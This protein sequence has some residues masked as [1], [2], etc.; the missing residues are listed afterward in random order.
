[1]T[2]NVINCLVPGA[3][4]HLGIIEAMTF[5]ICSFEINAVLCSKVCSKCGRK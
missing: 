1:M 4:S 5:D 2:T 3:G